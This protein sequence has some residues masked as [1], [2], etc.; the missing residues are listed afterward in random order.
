MCHTQGTVRLCLE[1]CTLPASALMCV[2]QQRH[3]PA[4][5]QVALLH[6]AIEC[7]CL[8]KICVTSGRIST[9][10]YPAGSMHVNDIV[11]EK[12]KQS[13]E[14]CLCDFYAQKT[15]ASEQLSR[16]LQ[17]PLNPRSVAQGQVLPR[18]ALR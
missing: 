5:R 12:A 18:L 9:D 3:Y 17:Y 14:A 1:S 4:S 13:E 16:W 2:H 10:H 11:M 7:V 6:T 15:E 8:L